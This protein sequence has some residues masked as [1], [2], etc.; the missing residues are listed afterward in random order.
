MTLNSGGGQYDQ[1]GD[2]LKQGNWVEI[3]ENQGDFS[4]VNWRGGYQNGKKIGRWDIFWNKNGNQKKLAEDHMMKEGINISWVIGRKQWIILSITLK[5]NTRENMQVV[6]KLVD[7]IYDQS[8]CLLI[9]TMKKCTNKVI[10]FQ[11][12]YFEQWLVI[13]GGGLYDEAGN[14]F[15]QGG[16]VEI[17]DNSDDSQV[18]YSG[19]F[20]NGKKQAFGILNIDIGEEIPFFKLVV[21]HMMKKELNLRM[22]IGQKF[23]IIIMILKQCREG[24]IQKEK[25][26]VDG[27]LC[28]K[29]I[30]CKNNI[31]NVQ[32]MSTHSGGG[33]YDEEN[34]SIKIGQWIEV[35]EE[36]FGCKQ[37]TYHGEYKNYR[38]AGRW[39]I[40]LGDNQCNSN[41]VKGLI[42]NT[43]SG[44]GLYD[45]EN[46]S[47]K[48][49]Q[50]IEL[51]E[52]FSGNNQITH[53]GNMKMEEKWGDGIYLQRNNQFKQYYLNYLTYF[54]FQRWWII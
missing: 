21:D 34:D 24:S 38:K 48:I 19:E 29:V 12:Q 33:L 27:F 50:W 49:G 31:K 53:H 47:I 17:L 41:Y 36:F 42:I 30:K 26:L 37:V 35:D 6:K 4:Y 54:N 9:I 3:T 18:T 16:W 44:G 8:I 15:K 13:N 25:K 28:T 14:G 7:G 40:L 51:D 32:I 23:R 10:Q 5:Q 11:Q 2:E 39:D 22:V 52:A 46:D 43:I 20:K 45:E 1:T